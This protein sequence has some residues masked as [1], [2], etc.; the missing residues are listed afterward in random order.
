MKYSEQFIHHP[1]KKQKKTK[2]SFYN[3]VTYNNPHVYFK[4]LPTFNIW[5][6]FICFCYTGAEQVNRSAETQ[7]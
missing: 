1:T 6:V 3:K 7:R 4:P 2:N 5:K